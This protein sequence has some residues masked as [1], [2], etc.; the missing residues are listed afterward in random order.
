VQKELYYTVILERKPSNE[1]FILSIPAFEELGQFEGDDAEELVNRA[2][3]V[4]E[5]HLETYLEEGRPIPV[6][7]NIKVKVTLPVDEE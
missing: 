5:A 4:L 3:T 6:E 1:G 7:M 2:T